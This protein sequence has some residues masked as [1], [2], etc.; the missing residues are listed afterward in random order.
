[1]DSLKELAEA[2]NAASDDAN[3]LYNR[4]KAITKTLNALQEGTFRV[5]IVEKNIAIAANV[6][7]EVA[8]WS[9]REA[10]AL[11]QDSQSNN[12]AQEQV[13]P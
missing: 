6:L 11:E 13:S 8:H 12:D 10:V 2:L 7:A 4:L 1:M 3:E 5:R 9:R